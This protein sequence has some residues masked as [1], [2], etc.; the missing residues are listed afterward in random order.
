MTKNELIESIML[1]KNHSDSNSGDLRRALD[2]LSSEIYAKEDRFIYELLQNACDAAPDAAEVAVTIDLTE[3]GI[4][5]FAH[6]GVPF[7]ENDVKALCGVGRSTKSNLSQRIGY[8]GIGF[9]SVFGQSSS[10]AIRSGGYCFRFDRGHWG[11]APVPWQVVPIWIEAGTMP[12]FAVDHDRT[13]IVLHLDSGSAVARH[14]EQMTVHPEFVLFLHSLNSLRIESG[15]NAWTISKHQMDGM[16][17]IRV[18]G[19]Q[20]CRY[21]IRTYEREVSKEVQSELESD[22]HIPEKMKHI[23]IV[24]V[25]LALPVG[26]DGKPSTVK[27]PLYAFFPM[28]EGIGLQLLVNSLFYTTASREAIPPEHLWNQFIIQEAATC[29]T[30][31]LAEMAR[32]PDHRAGMLAAVPDVHSLSLPLAKCF[33][34]ALQTAFMGNPCIPDFTGSEC[35]LVGESVHDSTG[36]LSAIGAESYLGAD[37]VCRCRIHSSLENTG[38]LE[39]FGLKSLGINDL[40]NIVSQ[41]SES[42]KVAQ[43]NLACALQLQKHGKGLET[44]KKTAWLL[45]T[46]GLLLCPDE[47][48]WPP[49]GSDSADSLPEGLHQVHEQIVKEAAQNLAFKSWLTNIGVADVQPSA[50]VKKILLPRLAAGTVL[51]SQSRFWIKI[52]FQAHIAG[53]LSVT[54]CEQIGTLQVNTRNGA[55]KPA[56]TCW[57]GLP[58]DTDKMWDSLVSGQPG[59]EFIGDEYLEYGG[60][61]ENWLKFFQ[62]IR[63]PTGGDCVK[64]RLL[65]AL[66]A[67]KQLGDVRFWTRAAFQAHLGKL[68]TAADYSILGEMLLETRA[69]VGMT[70]RKCWLGLPYNKEIDWEE[71]L[72]NRTDFYFV[73]EEYLELG[74]TLE[75]WADFFREIGVSGDI[76][77]SPI[78][79]K[80]RN[81]LIRD[82]SDYVKYID[83][84]GFIDSIYMSFPDQHGVEALYALNIQ[85]SV[86]QDERSGYLLGKRFLK[87]V[88]SS[89]GLLHVI[90]Y[91]YRGRYKY[92]IHSLISFYLRTCAVWP[93]SD[94]KCH[95]ASELIISGPSNRSL[96]GDDLPAIDPEEYG[97]SH[98][99]LA[100]Y[101]CRPALN[102]KQCLL[103]LNRI[104]ERGD[105]SAPT[106]ER[107]GRIYRRLESIRSSET[108]LNMKA[109]SAWMDN[110]AILSA[111]DT[112]CSPSALCTAS[113]EEILLL[114]EREECAF[115]GELNS[116]EAALLLT[117]LGV[118]PAG[119]AE[120]MIATCDEVAAPDLFR[121]INDRR[122]MLALLAAGQHA[123]PEAIA[124][125]GVLSFLELLECYQVRS[126]ALHQIGTSR[127]K[128][129]S[130]LCY[131]MVETKRLYF[132]GKL[133]DGQVMYAL[134]QELARVLKM[135]KHG[136]DIDLL[137]RLPVD[138][139]LEW[140]VAQGYDISAL[141]AADPEPDLIVSEVKSPGPK[142]SPAP[143]STTERDLHDPAVDLTELQQRCQE[144][145]YCSTQDPEITSAF[146]AKLLSQLSEQKSPWAGYAYHFTHVENLVSILKNQAI[147]SRNR[148][149]MFL[150]SAGQSLIAHTSDT[151]KEFARFYFRPLTPTQW[152]NECLGRSHGDIRALCPVP[153]FLRLPL[154]NVLDKVGNRCAVSNGNMASK[155]SHFG[156]HPDFLD[157]FDADNLYAKYGEISVQSYLAASQQEFLV[158]D[159]LSIADLPVTLICRNDQDLST[160]RYLM[161][162]H[163][164]Q[165][166][167]ATVIDPIYFEGDN[168]WL[169]VRIEQGRVAA[170]MKNGNKMLM[171]SFRLQAKPLSCSSAL[172]TVKDSTVMQ[173]E[174]PSPLDISFDRRLGL[175]GTSGA[176]VT[177]HYEEAGTEWLIYSGIL[178]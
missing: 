15:G 124:G 68:I 105:V 162:A 3:D 54:E 158:Q 2:K 48:F 59:F 66:K 92:K 14:L 60:S 161:H 143:K 136:H 21:L 62:S 24:P 50:I 11:E 63:V 4:L 65:P 44:I 29:L 166:S 123:T 152:H 89:D 23:S 88:I 27:Q 84:K 127:H 132:V 67:G 174:G 177:I 80:T 144:N 145:R 108:G 81:E 129:C 86:F 109:V 137:L 140:L 76:Q 70:A 20:V 69:G 116:D 58:Y 125:T 40:P 61:R 30:V 106:K 74:G 142:E 5:S 170:K 153:I 118:R 18:N 31:W 51:E 83:S 41:Y 135:P 94:K 134:A 90:Y 9:K 73:S 71:L 93:G 112:Y 45:T 130:K 156:N 10:V 165:D 19:G 167:C 155:S 120:I 168:P 121:M 172:Q 107:I 43:T 55:S 42:L 6:D 28:N 77:F 46:D 98:K 47:L 72:G 154:K 149:S 115:T 122:H 96:I 157:H 52:A 173:M 178:E 159:E 100:E 16:I 151:V 160:L 163:G 111:A 57:L 169:E 114:F 95:L 139:G 56:N 147:K 97:V 99:V 146:A 113:D 104:A 103:L 148:T 64:K 39:R 126:Y 8:K 82:Y 164:L 12:C 176:N 32:H 25:S 78:G 36:L 171:G 175:C 34:A 22:T 91:V 49:E 85:V 110:A 26:V 141:P 53:S 119:A 150:D 102:T 138:V 38:R 87:K 75:E 33:D 131:V 117:A 1:E 17:E 79:N 101:G 35:V 133:G 37:G 13:S 128:E 7:S